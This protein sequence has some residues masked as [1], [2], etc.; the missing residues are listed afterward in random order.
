MRSV[1]YFPKEYVLS[2][3]WPMYILSFFV[4]PLL[5]VVSVKKFFFRE[6]KENREVF[7]LETS[8]DL[9]GIAACVVMIHHFALRTKTP[10]KMF[11]YWF[12]GYI[13]VGVF[14]FLSGYASFFQL[15][16]KEEK[17]WDNYFPKRFFRLLLPFVITNSVYAIFYCHSISEYFEAMFTLRQIKGNPSEWSVV[18]FLAVILL[19][20]VLFW[21]SFRFV[22]ANKKIGVGIFFVGTVIFILVNRYLL[23]SISYWF[24][25]SLAYVTGIAYCMYKDKISDFVNRFKKVLIPI[26]TI[27]VLGIFFATTKGYQ[28]WW[29][30]VTCCELCL[31][32]FVTLEYS[33]QIRSEIFKKI[34]TASW[35]IFLI[36]PLV[37]VV[38]FSVFK[39]HFG[40][41]GVIC[42]AIGLTLGLLINA[43]DEKIFS[44][45]FGGRKKLIMSKN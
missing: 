42:I 41:S 43:L 34:G 30:Q 4:L 3:L 39:D 7:S 32:L 20:T 11:Y 38:Y 44:C 21:I 12:V 27:L 26:L 15:E 6:N 25:S 13:A 16:R 10:D 33:V 29:I 40:L 35:E 28:F 14:F 22:G 24:N 23:H 45:V 5:I 36:H 8:L 1:F 2:S 19:F 9:R 17:F 37:Y 18:W 31:C